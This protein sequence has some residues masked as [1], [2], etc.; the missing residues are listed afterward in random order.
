MNELQNEIY[1]HV[2]IYNDGVKDYLTDKEYKIIFQE[3]SGGG[4]GTWI[5]GK[6]IRFSNIARLIPYNEFSEKYNKEL[7]AKFPVFPYDTERLLPKNKE[8][9]IR[10][11][12]SMIRGFKITASEGNPM[13]KVMEKKL[14]L[15]KLDLV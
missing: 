14:E 3:S 11:L 6:Y 2:A 13:L 15:A 5:K 7:P 1:T 10:A 8:T 9:R 12:K 4:D